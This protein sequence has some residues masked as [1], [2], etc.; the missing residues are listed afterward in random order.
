MALQTIV[1][2]WPLSQFLDLLIGTLLIK[3]R[4]MRQAGHV[5]R[6][7]RSEMYTK[8]QSRNLKGRDCFGDL[9]ID[10][11]IIFIWV[12]LEILCGINVTPD[13][14]GKDAY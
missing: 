13:G 3:S 5:A 6:M 7:D 4:R 9:S 10:G 8:F 14:I 12:L 2:P 11:G 1:G